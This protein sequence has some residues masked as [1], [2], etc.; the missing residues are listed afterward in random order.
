MDDELILAGLILQFVVGALQLLI[1][2]I[3]TIMRRSK[4]VP[5]GNLKTYWI[6]VGVYSLGLIAL[7]F[8]MTVDHG[9]EEPCL[10]W[11][12]SA[13]GIAVYYMVQGRK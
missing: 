1:A 12:L 11:F 8:L 6:L 10:I 4:G 9:F 5:L 7:C 2:L 13:W 3:Q